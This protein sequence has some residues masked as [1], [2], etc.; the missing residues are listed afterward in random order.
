M[1]SKVQ[2]CN[3]AGI[4]VI[5]GEEGQVQNGGTATYGISYYNLGKLT[6][7]QAADKIRTLVRSMDDGRYFAVVKV[8][9]S[10]IG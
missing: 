5:C 4:P 8:E 1:I 3:E 10:Y 7:T 6:A 2:E 9:N